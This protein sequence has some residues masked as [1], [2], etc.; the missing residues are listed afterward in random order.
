VILLLAACHAPPTHPPAGSLGTSQTNTADTFDEAF[1]A[2]RRAASADLAEGYAS[3]ASVAVWKDGEIIFAEGF[4]TRSPDTDQEVAPTTLFEIGSDT[5]KITAIALLQQVEAGRLSVDTSIGDAVPDLAFT[6]D[7]GL[8]DALTLHELMSH[9]SAL[10]DYVPWDDAPDDSE[11]H[12]RA[13]GRYAENGYP[14]GPSGLFWDYS[15]PNYA[16]TGLAVEEAT[17]RAWAD[18]VEQDVF[19]PLGLKRSFARLS[20]AEADGDYATG[21]GL[22]VDGWDSFSPFF[23]GQYRLGTVEMDDAVDNAFLRP[24]GGVWSTASDM[25]RLAGF[26]VDGD[27]AVLSDP[28]REQ[29]TAAHVARWPDVDPSVLGYGYGIN[30]YNGFAGEEGFYRVPVWTHGGNTLTMTSTLYVAPEQRV[31]VSVLSNGYIDDFRETAHVALEQLADLPPPEE[32]P[33]L[34]AP[35][36]DVAALAGTW[37]DRYAVG[38]VTLSWD[39]A[40]LQ[41]DAPDLVAQGHSVGAPLVP[42]ALDSFTLAIDGLDRELDH[43]S[44][45]DGEYLVAREFGLE[46]VG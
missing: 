2:V 44:D 7:P 20:E 43:Y 39:G 1:R 36:G 37:T 19:A 35:P 28:L 46:R 27:A 22:S 16:L 5:K 45:A 29:I 25:A 12:D 14:L 18:V 8:E 10:F 33:E 24:A 38:T 41:V 21:Y 40:A 15:N 4:G 26:L 30:V 34:L 11:L 3:G 6:R 31:A 9:Q 42:F 32:V 17:G 13:V 23:D